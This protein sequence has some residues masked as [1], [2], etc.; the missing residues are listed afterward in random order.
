MDEFATKVSI[1]VCDVKKAILPKVYNRLQSP[2]GH[3]CMRYFGPLIM[4]GFYFTQFLHA[5]L[6]YQVFGPALL[7]VFADYPFVAYCW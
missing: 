7:V 2:A 6:F 5:F 1:F 3:S 4:A